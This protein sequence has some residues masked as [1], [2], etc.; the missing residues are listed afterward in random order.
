MRD[1]FALVGAY[2]HTADG[3]GERFVQAYCRV[4]G[5][6]MRSVAI[7]IVR[8]ARLNIHSVP[9]ILLDHTLKDEWTSPR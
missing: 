1:F 6:P 9:L 2:S 8:Y 5:V 3:V 7:V 4:L